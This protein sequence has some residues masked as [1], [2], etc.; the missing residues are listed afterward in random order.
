VAASLVFVVVAS[1]SAVAAIAT[2]PLWQNEPF[3]EHT[4]VMTAS[5]LA[6]QITGAV[7]NLGESAHATSDK[8]NL[9]LVHGTNN[10]VIVVAEAVPRRICPASG[11][12]L[13]RKGTVTINGFAPAVVS[14]AAIT[15]LCFRNAGN[16]NITWS[17]KPS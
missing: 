13:A 12:L 2:H 17:P 10:R 15:A 7:G 4:N 6:A 3:A 1:V 5:I 14:K 11:W 8:T 9:Q 16:A